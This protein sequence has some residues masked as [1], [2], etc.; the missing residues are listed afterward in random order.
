MNGGPTSWEDSETPTTNATVRF[1]WEAALQT[2]HFEYDAN[3]PS[4]GVLWVKIDSKALNGPITNWGMNESS[5]FEISVFGESENITLTQAQN[6]WLDDFK[7]ET[8]TT[9]P[10]PIRLPSTHLPSPTIIPANWSSKSLMF[11]WAARCVWRNISITMVTANWGYRTLI[12]SLRLTDGYLPTIGGVRNTSVPGDEDNTLDGIIKMEIR[13]TGPIR[14]Q[15]AGCSLHLSG[16][17]R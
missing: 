1:R 12:Q 17:P 10:P 7:I 6:I 8:N 15:S 16:S 13:F 9:H 11:P 3:G 5:T 4:D 14:D 2:L